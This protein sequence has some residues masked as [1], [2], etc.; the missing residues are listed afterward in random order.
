M[1]APAG[2]EATDER[3]YLDARV[4]YWDRIAAMNDRRAWAGR[5]Y[6]R[7][8]RQVYGNLVQ[9]GQRVLEL[10]CGYG[11]LLAALRPAVGVGVDLSPQMVRRAADRHP[12]LRFAQG[13][14][15]HWPVDVGG[16]PFDYI[17]L[18]DLVGELWDV[19]GTLDTIA[20][21]SRRVPPLAP[22]LP[23]LRRSLTRTPAPR[24]GTARTAVNPG[25]AGG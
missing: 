11:D 15:G 13:D 19:Q 9:P 16:P 1:E 3:A 8:L 17:I 20:R 21:E 18:S 12:A 22:A 4:A 25:R 5:H 2:G 6:H 24:C 10:G 23:R 7:R 14:A